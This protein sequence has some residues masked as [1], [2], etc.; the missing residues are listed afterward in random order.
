[1]FL[2]FKNSFKILFH[3]WEYPL[4]MNSLI[5]MIL[6]LCSGMRES[7]PSTLLGASSWVLEMPSWKFVQ[8]IYNKLRIQSLILRK[9][10]TWGRPVTNRM[11]IHP[12]HQLKAMEKHETITCRSHDT[13]AYLSLQKGLCNATMTGTFSFIST[14]SFLNVTL[15][16]G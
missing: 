1:M 11:T 13:I 8:Q 15:P 12:T 4:F 7:F 14:F 5:E 9:W 10:H 3:F 6:C 2:P 16:L